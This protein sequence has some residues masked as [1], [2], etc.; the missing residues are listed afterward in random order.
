ML[1]QRPGHPPNSEGKT[2]P[3]EAQRK[4]Q[5]DGVPEI[6]PA[7]ALRE[8]VYRLLALG[9]R[10]PSAL[11]R[12]ALPEGAAVL[13]AAQALSPSPALKQA[14]DAYRALLA[15]GDG[16]ASPQETALEY[17]RLFVG[18]GPLACPPYG[19]VY[20]DG[21]VVMGPSTLAAL[22]AYEE[23]GLKPSLKEPPDHI[24]V[25]LEFMAHLCQGASHAAD[26]S[27]ARHCLAL[28]ETF[29]RE[30]LLAW[31]PAFARRLL[32][33][34]SHPLYKTLAGLLVAWL[35]LDRDLINASL[36]VLEGP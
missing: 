3:R 5:R 24:A 16:G 32:A 15:Q 20:R 1:A 11:L 18:P 27:Q 21:G 17:C 34:T 28:Q 33:D 4:A 22:R 30:H 23:Q 9:F 29:L 25:E 26:I 10:Q 7:I 2:L 31:A 14:V 13:E 12:E 6:G 19:S 8:G 36:A 35:P